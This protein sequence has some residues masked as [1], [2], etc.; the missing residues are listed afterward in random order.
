M[1]LLTNLEQRWALL[2]IDQVAIAKKVRA[3]D[4]GAIELSHNLEKYEDMDELELEREFQARLK[5]G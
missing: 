1:P 4:L 3:G 2:D 5:K